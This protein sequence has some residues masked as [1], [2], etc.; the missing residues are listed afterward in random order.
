MDST[1][2]KESF[3]SFF[4]KIGSFIS[5]LTELHGG[6]IFSLIAFLL[7]FLL[8]IT[9]SLFNLDEY[10]TAV[11]YQ[12]GYE[13]MSPQSK[14]LIV[15]KDETNS[16]LIDK[17][18]GRNDYSSIIR[19]LG[20]PREEEFPVKGNNSFLNLFEIKIGL[21]DEK[22]GKV[23]YSFF[24]K[25]EKDFV[26]KAPAA[27][28]DK[29]KCFFKYADEIK[30]LIE[31]EFPSD[32]KCD[33]ASLSQIIFDGMQ[34]LKKNVFSPVSMEMQN[35][36]SIFFYNIVTGYFYFSVTMFPDDKTLIKLALQVFKPDPPKTFHIPEAGVISLDFI[37]QGEKAP[38]EDRS[39]CDAISNSSSPLVLAGQIDTV[40]VLTQKEEMKDRISAIELTR[41]NLN[42]STVKRN[43]LPHEKFREIKSARIGY[44]NIF[45]TSKGYVTKIP[46]FQYIENEDRIE[47]SFSLV[48]VVIYL[49]RM[50]G[51]NKYTSAMKAEMKRI[52]PD[53]KA[54]TYKG[55]LK[56]EDIV[57]PTDEKGCM[58][59]YY[60]GATDPRIYHGKVKSSAI[61][62]SVSFY[63]CLNDDE[64]DL[65]AKKNPQHHEKLL[66]KTAHLRTAQPMI[67]F[68]KR[69][70]LL[71][72]FEKSDFDFYETPLSLKTAYQII[73]RTL[74]GIEIHAN[75]I[76]TILNKRFIKDPNT[77]HTTLALF[78]FTLLLGMLLDIFSPL[79]GLILSI[80]GICGA[81][82][83]GYYSYNTLGQI[84]LFS[85]FL[86]SFPLTWTLATLTN[87]LRQLTRANSTKAMFSRFVSADVVHYMV[88]H[89]DL[90]KPGGQKVEMTVFFSDVAGFTSISEALTPEELV[91][92]L[93]EYLG[94]MTD[95]LFKYG[96]TLDKF[97]GDAVM[98]FWNYPRTQP[99][100]AIRGCLCALEMQAT[101][102]ELQKGWA[103]RGLPK[104][105]ARAGMNTADVVVGYMGSLKAQMN[106]TCMG[107]GVNLASRLEGANKEYGTYLMISD[108][109]YQQAKDRV[110]VRRLDYLAVKGKKE[111]VKVYQLV[112]EKG[113]EPPDWSD[114]VTMYDKA[115]DLHLERKWDEAIGIF[116]NILARWPEDGPSKTYLSR[117]QEYKVTPPPDPWDG[118]YHLTHK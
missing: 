62:P 98:A 24:Y 34:D 113:K 94:T 86:I 93:N 111:P 60:Y 115:Y 71:G 30:A 69:I 43:I 12:A 105:A 54:K 26:G 58:N 41:T 96:G 32:E 22:P 35:Y 82:A 114:L 100:H 59:V 1:Q 85:P 83:Y 61:F 68:G 28:Q 6:V 91:V 2:G 80:S 101:I 37:L 52:L 3:W 107:D 117:C 10:L 81:G 104:V 17:N 70:C 31:F 99:D 33:L 75:A 7:S 95:I 53:V 42:K 39:L 40:E 16:E 92:L 74:M 9:Q 19:Y 84:F 66:P 5:Q 109:T 20:S 8:F 73:P 118:S 38:E 112:C 65:Y 51:N 11:V 56:I 88:E 64:L 57:I 63:E 23:V 44:I 87:Y 15:K 103:K 14:F 47:P 76:A 46:I 55:G 36:L 79:I 97:I 27:N 13:E 77:L 116:E 78:I 45:T 48:S 90:V 67:N 4:T 72:P 29:V 25:L 21:F 89:P 110:T 49:D 108:K 106:F 50:N 18:P 102:M